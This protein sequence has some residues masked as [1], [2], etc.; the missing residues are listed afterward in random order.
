MNMD[1]MATS[2]NRNP[3]PM[4]VAAAIVEEGAAPGDQQ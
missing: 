1:R 4:T 3:S 2:A